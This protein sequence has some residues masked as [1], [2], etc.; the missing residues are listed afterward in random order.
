MNP[1]NRQLD[2]ATFARPNAYRYLG[3]AG[4]LLLGLL[5]RLP[6][7]HGLSTSPIAGQLQDLAVVQALFAGD[8][9]LIGPLMDQS[10]FHLG[11]AYYYLSL[12]LAWAA[13]FRPFGLALTSLLF[14]LGAIL[15]L[16]H[17]GRQWYADRPAVA[18]IA[19][20]LL[21]V[22][23]LDL[24]FAKYGA[25]PNTLPFFALMLLLA[26]TPFLRGRGR[27]THAAL[28]G[29][30][31]GIGL[32]LHAVGGTVMTIFLLTVVLG[33]LVRPRLEALV[34]F[35]FASL[36]ANGPYL[37][38]LHLDGFSDIISLSQLAAAVPDPSAWLSRLS[39]LGAL[40]VSLGLNL[41]GRFNLL[42]L[43]GWTVMYILAANIVLLTAVFLF[44]KPVRRSAGKPHPAS[45]LLLLWLAASQLTLLFPWSRL[46]HI[47][48]DHFALTIPIAYLLGAVMID[49]LLRSG[50]RATATL[51]LI[52]FLGWQSFQL[53]VY[54]SLYPHLLLQLIGLS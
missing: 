29:L 4:L 34:A 47:S 42:G 54:H 10:A 23:A 30:A 40:W 13:G 1:H 36:L 20:S 16:W 51:A 2:P 24:Q 48:V 22:S 25:S 17:L 26:I 5:L 15:L 52:S 8:P 38:G 45:Q 27:W 31:Y 11:P 44:D 32:Q 43:H 39:D 18:W 12:P 9:V 6:N 49:Q 41:H 50:R 19:A 14:S 33:R 46:R 53:A 3:L 37:V 21:T 35:L 7:L 28:A